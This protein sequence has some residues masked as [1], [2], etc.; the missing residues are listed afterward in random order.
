MT[1]EQI[2]L[3]T[4]TEQWGKQEGHILVLVPALS[5]LHLTLRSINGA[6]LSAAQLSVLPKV[7]KPSICLLM[8]FSDILSFISLVVLF[9]K[10]AHVII[11][12]ISKEKLSNGP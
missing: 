4:G 3:R 8:M 7:G 1:W 11:C 9:P 12:G 5:F 2:Q 6:E 10:F